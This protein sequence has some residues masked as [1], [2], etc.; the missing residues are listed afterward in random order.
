MNSIS[1][2]LADLEVSE[3]NEITAH[4][5]LGFTNTSWVNAYKTHGP[6]FKVAIGEREYTVLCGHDANLEAWRRP[7]DW[8][9]RDT[10]SGSFFRSEMGQSHVTQL[11][12][13]PHRRLRKLIL[14]AIGVKALS[15]DFEAVMASMAKSIAAMPRSTFDLFD[16]ANIAYADALAV[17]QV[18]LDVPP[19]TIKLLADFEDWFIGGLRISPD[20][21]QK[22]HATKEYLAIKSAAYDVFEQV[23]AERQSGVRRN[24]SFDMM[25]D[26]PV[27]PGFLPLDQDELVQAVY[28]LSVAGVGNIANQLSAAVWFLTSHPEWLDR[29]RH[30]LDHT[31][32]SLMKSGMVNFP[33]LKA[34]ISEMERYYQPAPAIQKITTNALEILGQHIPAGESVLHIHGLAHFDSDHYE[35]PYEFNPGRWLEGSIKKPLAFG[36]GKHLCLG[37]GVARLF[38]PLSLALIV[39]DYAIEASQAPMSVTLAPAIASSPP[40]T[41]FEVKLTPRR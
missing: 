5:M 29:L 32:V 25:F 24:D 33:I 12:G 23:V 18:K 30:E 9:Y 7:D 8:N 3:S 16:K 17:S 37:M 15:R 39:K 22:F 26:Q 4:H 40:T 21:Q 1:T 10:D 28:L 11:N 13:E 6:V 31:D 41:R 2:P 34:V 27:M 38:V 20:Q 36:G 14:P 35:R 19:E